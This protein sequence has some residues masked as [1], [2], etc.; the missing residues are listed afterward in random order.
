[1]TLNN[2]RVQEELL[3]LEGVT[4]H[5]TPTHTVVTRGDYNCHVSNIRKDEKAPSHKFL[6]DEKK[7]GKPLNPKHLVLRAQVSYALGKADDQG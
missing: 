2:F 5:H 1:M 3:K 7:N 4:I 6:W